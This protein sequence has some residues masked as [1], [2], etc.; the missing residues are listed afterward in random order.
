M[1]N[2]LQFVQVKMSREEITYG[3]FAETSRVKSYL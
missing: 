1:V 2:M 3:K